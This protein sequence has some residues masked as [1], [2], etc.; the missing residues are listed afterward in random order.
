MRSRLSGFASGIDAF[1]LLTPDANAKGGMLHDAFG[2]FSFAHAACNCGFWY[3]RHCV[4][5]LQQQKMTASLPNLR[6]FFVE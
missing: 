3:V 1:L 6:S 2:N 4:E 5:D